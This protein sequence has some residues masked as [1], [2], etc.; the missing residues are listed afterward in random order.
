MSSAIDRKKPSL[1]RTVCY[2]IFPKLGRR[3]TPRLSGQ[4]VPTHVFHEVYS[5]LHNVFHEV[6]GKLHVVRMLFIY[7]SS[8]QTVYK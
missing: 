3:Q 4:D 8:A 7:F 1:L 6:Y 5:K 2:F